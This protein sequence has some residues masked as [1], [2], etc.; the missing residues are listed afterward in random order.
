MRKAPSRLRKTAFRLKEIKLIIIDNKTLRGLG[1][2]QK[3]FRNSDGSPRKVKAEL[4][5]DSIVAIKTI[6]F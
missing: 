1:S 5:L 2:F 3:D 6:K 4:G